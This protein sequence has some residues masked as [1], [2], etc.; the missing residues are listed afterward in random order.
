MKQTDVQKPEALRL[1][2]CAVEIGESLETLV[3]IG[4][5]DGDTTLQEQYE[6]IKRI[7]ANAGEIDRGIKPGSH[8]ATISGNWL[9]IDLPNLALLRGGIDQSGTV[10]GTPV[11]GHAQTI[12]AGAWKYDEFIPFDRQNYDGAKI[13][14]ESVVASTDGAL[15]LGTDY[16]IIKNAAGIWGIA[17]PDSA[18]VT[19]EAQNIVITFGYTPAASVS[20][21]TGGAFTIVPRVVRLTNTNAA[22]KK[23]VGTFYK[24]FNT[25]GLNLAFKPDEDGNYMVSPFEMECVCDES[26]PAKDQLFKLVDEQG[27]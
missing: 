23:L 14:P 15:V 1:G 20:L 18:T 19:T 24:G 22:G 11:S 26:R 21:S 3:N 5:T 13:T 2:S 8:I 9:E 12:L 7:S 6:I 25:K 17:I 10:A 4:A 16:F 27:V